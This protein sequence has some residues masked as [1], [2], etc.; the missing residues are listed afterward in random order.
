[1]HLTNCK[2][3][4]IHNHSMHGHV[5]SIHSGFLRDIT[6]KDESFICQLFNE[7]DIDFYYVRQT[8]H[9]DSTVFTSFMVNSNITG[10]GLTDIIVNE[11]NKPVGLIS[12]EIVPDEAERIRWNLGYAVL[13][14]YRHKGYA[15]NSLKEYIRILEEFTINTACLDISIDNK[16]SEA[17]A[18]KC[19]FELRDRCGFFD[20]EHPEIR[21][22]RHWYK[23]IH[24]H[25]ARIPFF[26]RANTAYH[27]KEYETAIS[28]YKEAL[29]IPLA[30]DSKLNDAQIYANLGM[31]YSSIGDYRQAFTYLRRA[32]SLGLTN[33]TI[34]KEIAWLK[35]NIG[36][37]NQKL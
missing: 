22:R 34:I 5:I 11:L 19:G 31:T 33:P 32:V 12:A 27:N 21:L 28:I 36:I 14:T 16:V 2:A 17:V 7:P 37:D 25:D 29:H 4:P 9:R 13:P 18:K 6:L 35:S 8:C 3:S 24:S 20:T 10:R 30:K 26:Q 15:S 1:M 23:T